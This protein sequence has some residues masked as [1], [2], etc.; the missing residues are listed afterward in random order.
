MTST[1]AIFGEEDGT[2]S[3]RLARYGRVQAVGRLA[4][5]EEARLKDAFREEATALEQLT[6]G[7]YNV[8]VKGTGR[9]LQTD[10]QPKAFVEDRTEFEEWFKVEHPD[11]VVER[12]VV[13]I[14]DH[15][16]LGEA[17]ALASDSEAVTDV[18]DALSLIEI[19]RESL[20]VG[21]T[22]LLPEDVFKTLD[23]LGYEEHAWGYV[24]PDGEKVPGIGVKTA[25]RTM[26][27]TIEA[28][29]KKKYDRE[30]HIA[31]LGNPEE[32]DS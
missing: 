13:L 14:K 30:L 17:L 6:G 15:D 8:P 23:S 21:V 16:R 31:L 7:S 29:A 11:R 27:V 1:L 32:N 3:A 2:T 10:P 20:E 9:V 22:V 5:S 25:K 28:G 26:T 12:P 19:F 4:K 18:F 24:T